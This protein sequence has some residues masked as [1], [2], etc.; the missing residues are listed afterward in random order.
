MSITRKFLKGMGLTD[1]QQDTIL[2]AHT[3]TVDEIKAERDRLKT[4]AANLPKLQKQL[5][6]AQADL[7]AAQQDGWKD[8]HDSLKKEFED[9]KAGVTAKETKAA[10][11]AAVR[12][13]YE[14]KG[15]TGKAL[16]IAMR[17]SGAEIEALELADGKIKDAAALDALVS[18]DFSGLVGQTRTEGAPTATPPFNNGGGK[19]RKDVLKMS[20]AERAALYQEN[21]D[22][23]NEI[24]KGD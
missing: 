17:G 8:K 14:S 10:K 21:P 3:E 15:I 24:M 18:G 4:E 20:Y 22:K 23:F 7:A 11:T 12:A 5:E 1:E 2:E 13:Y 19:T 6:Q 9:Y 16:D